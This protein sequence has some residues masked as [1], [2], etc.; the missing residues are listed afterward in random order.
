MYVCECLYVQIKV[1]VIAHF[2]NIYIISDT[3]SYIKV[4]ST[5]MTEKRVAI[6]YGKIS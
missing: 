6:I 1:S 5:F 2:T 4:G 3:N